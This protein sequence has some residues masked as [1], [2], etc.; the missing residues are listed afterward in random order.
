MP[1]GA[2]P[3]RCDPRPASRPGA[4][5]RNLRTLDANMPLRSSPGLTTGRSP[6]SEQRKTEP[7]DVAILARPHDRAQQ[8]AVVPAG[9]LPGVAILARPH[10]R[11]QD[12]DLSGA[13]PVVTAAL[14]SSPGLTTGRRR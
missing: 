11:A 1:R 10:D 5:S 7:E 12:A 9:G 4:V 8:R 6:P 3:R 13:E 2:S 14:R